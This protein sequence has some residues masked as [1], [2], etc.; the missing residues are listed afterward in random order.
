MSYKFDL[1]G[2]ALNIQNACSTPLVAVCLAVQSS[3]RP[4]SATWH[5][6]VRCRSDSRN[7]G[8]PS[9]KKGLILSPGRP[10]PAVRRR[11]GRHGVQQ[12]AGIVVLRR[13]RDAL[14][15]GNTIYAVIKGA[16]L[17]NDGGAK[18]DSPHPASTV[19]RR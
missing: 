8:I 13:L 5:W 7:G 14:A 17:N 3:G 16:A 1:Q 6:P 4:T 2:P 12:R 15:D 11:R 19:T 9:T 10:L 18:V